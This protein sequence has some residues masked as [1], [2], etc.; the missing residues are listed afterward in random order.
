LQDQLLS[1]SHRRNRLLAA[2]PDDVYGFL[3]EAM[4][5]A[6]FTLDQMIYDS[7]ETVTHV[8]FPHDCILSVVTIME[9]GR[10]TECETIGSEGCFG[11][12]SGFGDRRTVNRCVAQIPGTA[13]LLPIERLDEALARYPA[14][15]DILMRYLRAVMAQIQRSV[16][17]SSLHTADL[18]CA[19]KLLRLHDWAHRDTFP[20]KQDYLAR[21]L[22]VRR[23]TVG[24]ICARLQDEG[25][26]R[27]SRGVM[28]IL[29]RP[30]LEAA[31]CECYSAI[32]RTYERLLPK[33]F[34]DR[35]LK[36]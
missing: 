10:S 33:T 18:R 6:D 31:T 14:L 27:Y 15:H 19:R 22:G 8:V 13:S 1:N 2:L 36:S 5:L 24:E 28:T 21:A 35:P 34:A 20:V 26:I 30:R 32:S 4:S 17:C 9:D 25:I 3:A 11:F 12:L 23:A 16:A 29:D 7:G